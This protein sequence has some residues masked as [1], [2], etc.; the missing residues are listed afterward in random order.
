MD[1]VNNR[2]PIGAGAGQ[3]ARDVLLRRDRGIWIVRRRFGGCAREAK[4]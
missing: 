2:G 4:Q 3:H 1:E